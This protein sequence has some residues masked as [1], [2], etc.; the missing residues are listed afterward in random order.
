M[1]HPLDGGK[2]KINRSEVIL[3]FNRQGIVLPATVNGKG[4]GLVLRTLAKTEP[5]TW[6]LPPLSNS[7]I[8]NIIWLYKTLNR[9]PN[10]DCYWG[11]QYP[12]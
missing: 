4:Q 2:K 11:G 8:I 10:R 12:T 3:G 1:F 9:T 7:W 6:V 5:K